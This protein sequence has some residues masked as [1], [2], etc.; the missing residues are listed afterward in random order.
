MFALIPTFI[1]ISFFYRFG[2]ISIGAL[3]DFIADFQSRAC[4]DKLSANFRLYAF[5]PQIS[6][7]KL[8]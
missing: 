5:I 7:T 4:L 8:I 1:V 6:L 2:N 3:H